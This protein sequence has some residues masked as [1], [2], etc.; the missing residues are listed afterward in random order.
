[1]REYIRLR[2]VMSWFLA[3][4]FA[5]GLLTLLSSEREIF[6]VYSWFLFALVPQADTQYALLLEEADGKTIEPPCLY[7]EGDGWVAQ[8]HS[9]RVFQL[10]QKLGAACERNLPE[11]A[12]YRELLEK[13][14]L[15]ARTR[16]ELVKVN[17]DPIA[18]WQSGRYEITRRLQHF[19]TAG[20]TP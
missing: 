10:V 11:Q 8:P 16:Y 9:V 14:W 20:A 17:G 15:P 7:Q 12:R 4:Y 19:T 2:K 1:M 6:P 3:A 18:R 13:N 5:G